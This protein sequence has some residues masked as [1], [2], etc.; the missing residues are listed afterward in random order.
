MDAEIGVCRFTL[1]YTELLVLS[2][3]S[4]CIAQLQTRSG[5]GYVLGYKRGIGPPWLL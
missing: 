1:W 5:H 4:H 3:M 2:D